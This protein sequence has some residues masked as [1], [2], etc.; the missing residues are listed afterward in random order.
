MQLL[1]VILCLQSFCDT[2]Q[3]V[4]FGSETATG[5]KTNQ[6]TADDMQDTCNAMAV[7]LHTCCLYAGQCSP[8]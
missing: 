3:L 2:K 5:P 4:C 1:A 7:M 6:I 8:Y